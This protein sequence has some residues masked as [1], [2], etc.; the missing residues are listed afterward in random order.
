[1]CDLLQRQ[2]G[3]HDAVRRVPL[4]RQQDVTDLVRHDT[5]QQHARIDLPFFLGTPSSAGGAALTKAEYIAHVFDGTTYDSLALSEV[6]AR[7]VGDSAIVTGI[8]HVKGRDAKGQP[9]DV[10]VRFT[11]TWVKRN[12]RWLAIASQGTQLPRKTGTN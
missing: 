3:T 10:R 7:V 6:A 12:G 8:N 4:V 2:V 11:D 5:G 1:M 9:I